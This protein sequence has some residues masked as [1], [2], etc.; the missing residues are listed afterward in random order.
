MTARNIQVTTDVYAAIWKAQ[1][2]GEGIENDIL[3]RVL[4]VR[5]A[6]AATIGATGTG[7]RDAT[8]T[9]YR[10][11]RFG[12]EFPEGFEIFRTYL[13]KNYRAKATDGLWQL[14]QTGELYRDRNELS[15]AIGAKVENAWVNWYYV[16]PNGD[17]AVVSTLRDH[18]KIGG[19]HSVRRARTVKSKST[20]RC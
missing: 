17:R 6:K 7:Y 15:R 20:A 8:G 16:D 11:P 18:A 2:E 3:A 4:G 19:G 1:E 12:V 14:E 13:G 5:P 9:G 10:D